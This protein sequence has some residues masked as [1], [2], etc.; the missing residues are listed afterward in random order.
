MPG[1]RWLDRRSFPSDTERCQARLQA[2]EEVHDNWEFTSRTESEFDKFLHDEIVRLRAAAK[3][4]GY[5]A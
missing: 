4:A 1:W 2:F 3:R 5:H